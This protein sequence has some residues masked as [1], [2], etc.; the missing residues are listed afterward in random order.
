MLRAAA[1]VEKLGIPTASIIGSGFLKQA[2][3]IVKGQGVPLAIGVYP[4]APMVD[5]EA[6]LKRK[7]EEE[8][9]PGLLRGLTGEAPRSANAQAE[10]APGE[11]VFR[12]T[13]DEVQEHFHRQLWS[14]GL[15][16]VPPTRERVDAFLRFTDRDPDEVLRAI[17][18][19][20]REATIR[21]IAVNAV[22]AGCRPEYMPLLIAVVEAM[23]DPNYRVE[24]SGSTPGWEPVVIVSGPI[25][26][27]L[28][29]NSGQGMMRVG[30]QANTSIGRFVRLYL[31]NVCGFRIPPGAGDKGSIGQS[32]LVAMAED[33]DA[34]RAIGWPTYGEDRGFQPGENVVT[35]RSVVAITSPIYSASDRAVEHVQ[36]WTDVIGGSFT[37]WAHTGFKTGLWSPLIV[38][39]PSIAKVVAGEWSKDQ[40]RK[41][42]YQHIKVSA[43]KATHYAR[44]TTTPT[45]SFENLVRDKLLPPEYAASPDPQRLV[46]VIIDPAM[47]E[48]LVAGDAGRNQSRAYMS[49]HVQ[50]PPTSRRIRL[51][52]RWDELLEA[53][54]R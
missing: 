21:S 42:L 35:V 19:E 37:Y 25:A 47:V 10:P 41:Y 54:R 52:A 46:N 39:G 51:P 7:V 22:M 26:K 33:E 4:G 27:T 13:F 1:V 5:S 49:N 16:V 15:P 53:A 9:A 43:E 18:Q 12:G 8:L 2:E 31:R 14:D 17:P 30:R 23:C 36:Q 6:E 50:G 48:I 3:V 45:F 28:D 34:A 44:M 29:F 20:G 38:A 11:I 32:F 24:D 40:V